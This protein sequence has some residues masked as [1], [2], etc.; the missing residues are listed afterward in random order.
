MQPARIAAETP[1]HRARF[2]V[3]DGGDILRVLD[4]PLLH[5]LSAPSPRK[6]RTSENT[7]FP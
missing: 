7:I 6:W 5:D 3:L 4:A 2:A 1:H